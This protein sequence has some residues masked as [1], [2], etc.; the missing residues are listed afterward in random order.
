V[1]RFLRGVL[2]SQ[3]GGASADGLLLRRYVEARDEDAF[4]ALVKRHGP[5]VLGL[6]RRLLGDAHDAEDA[7]QATFVVLAKKA[8]TLRRPGL[9]GNWLYGVAYRVGVRARAVRARRRARE[10]QAVDLPGRDQT[11]DVIWSD[12][13][14]VLD[15]EVSRL[16]DKYRAPFVLCYLQGKTN[17]E[18]AALLGAPKGTVLSRLATARERLRGRLTR[19]GITLSAGLLAA[20]L[21]RHA[22]AAVPPALVATVA[23]AAGIPAGV[24]ALA[25][26]VVKAM[27]WSKLR[28]TGTLILAAAAIVAGTWL[29]PCWGSAAGPSEPAAAAAP[30]PQ[31]ARAAAKRPAAARGRGYLI[32]P[33][34]TELQR[35]FLDWDRDTA[36]AIVLLDGVSLVRPDGSVDGK[37]LDFAGLREA[38]QPYRGKGHT[39]V[40]NA[41]FRDPTSSPVEG[42]RVLAWALEGFSRHAGFAKVRV[43]ETFLAATDYDWEKKTAGAEKGP[44][45]ADEPATGNALVKVYPVR[46]ALSRLQTDADCVAEILPLLEAR[47]DDQ[48]KPGVREALRLYIERLRLPHKELVAFRVRVRPDESGREAAER[49]RK[50]TAEP[51]ARS[52]G[53]KTYS[54]T[55]NQPY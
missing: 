37:A 15:E 9:L 17:E 44:V 28:V 16:P 52:L 11:P 36:R 33:V 22:A 1:L 48:L 5:M 47:G 2:A 34:T 35:T 18:A 3:Q 41:W 14:P 55:T 50:T 7:F 20:A 32:L 6:C 10:R 49:F 31:A 23:K 54:V 26:G 46:T 21:A 12:L 4:A 8:A 24:A 51:L 27:F 39:I 29:L 43:S 13:R 25:E 53:F 40:L 19:R 30:P 45:N 42:R 38:L